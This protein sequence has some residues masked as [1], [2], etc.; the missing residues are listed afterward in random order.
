M[1]KRLT[2]SIIFS[3]AVLLLIA[4]LVN[5]LGSVFDLF[6][7]LLMILRPLIIG[8]ATAFILNKPF[9]S[10][11]TLYMKP[12]EKKWAKLKKPVAESVRK[13]AYKKMQILALL[14]SYIIFLAAV[15][16]LV[17][18]VVP[19]FVESM[20][21]FSDNFEGY[22]ENFKSLKI[23]NTPIME[24]DWFELLEK[25]NVD[26]MLRGKLASV[27]E[28]IPEFF[29]KAFSITYSIIK[30]LI[31]VALGFVLSIYIL[32]GKKKLKH[33]ASAVTQAFLPKKSSAVVMKYARIISDSFSVF[34]SV[35]FFDSLILG[36]LCFI[37]M[38]VLGF[39]YAL[40]I[41]TIIGLTNMLPIIGPICG[42]LPCAL[43]L[44]F[45]K[46]IDAFWF[47]ILVIILQQIDSNIIYP[48][49][50]GDNIGLPAIYVLAVIIIGGGLFSLP[51]IL[52]GIPIA[53]V[54]YRTIGDY[55]AE[56][57]K[58]KSEKD[59]VPVAQ[60]SDEL[61]FDDKD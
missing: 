16:G 20:M 15:T 60:G 47:I 17:C 46:P 29:T 51:G 10:I 34:F 11:H 55:V 19:Q 52:L 5:S 42:A 4:F 3:G 8:A 24:F 30:V 48:R 57:N 9:G 40:V 6:K 28:Y 39:D 44:F 21:I 54:L 56:K 35:Q 23:G 7:A 25:Y 18:F 13:K 43:I 22:Y 41:S 27:T 53:S 38:T 2:K 12:Y 61:F 58:R 32:A 45:V 26:E 1:D 49:V 31:D 14:T 33:Q 59:E 50:V 36:L 37:S